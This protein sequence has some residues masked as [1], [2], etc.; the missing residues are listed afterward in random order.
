MITFKIDPNIE[1]MWKCI[2]LNQNE[3]VIEIEKLESLLNQTYQLFVSNTNKKMEEKRSELHKVQT[4]FQNLKKMYGDTSTQLPVNA[5]L[6]LRG[7]IEITNSAIIDL[8][9]YYEPRVHAIK[10]LSKKICE[11]SNQLGISGDE[12][13][14]YNVSQS[15]DF[16]EQKL[17]GFKDRFR[18]LSDEASQRYQLFESAASQVTK[19]S[20]ELEEQLDPEL[21]TI[22]ST[23]ILTNEALK[24]LNEKSKSLLKLKSQ[25]AKEIQKLT[26]EVEHLYLILAVDPQDRIEKQTALTE[27]SIQLLTNEIEF[28][29]EQKETRLPEV[30]KGLTK[31][32]TKVCD[33]LRVPSRLRPKYLGDDIEEEAAF[34]SEELDNLRNQ[35]IEMQPIIDSISRLETLKTENSQSELSTSR[36]SNVSYNRTKRKTSSNREEIKKEQENLLSLLVRFKE[37]HGYDFEFNGINYLQTISNVRINDDKS[38]G[39][40]LLKEKM[41]ESNAKHSQ[42]LYENHVSK[43][44]SH[45]GH[46]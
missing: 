4:N 15:Q 38:L 19:L 37:K 11:L 16:S 20:E 13:E 10:S 7:Q 39:R 29:N 6:S 45:Y 17:K 30:V 31:E 3:R 46:L 32:I 14:K 1:Y 25:R 43:I 27:N 42:N 8:N 23:K 2:G 5:S 36:R 9:K 18:S 40:T 22:I 28:L 33:N 21:S 41:L 34:L 12:L 26:E 24:Q 44:T 35:Q